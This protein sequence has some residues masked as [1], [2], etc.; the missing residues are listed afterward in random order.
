MFFLR[1]YTRRIILPTSPNT[2]N[3]K[4]V[5]YQWS[6]DLIIDDNYTML[7]PHEWKLISAEKKIRFVT[8]LSNAFSKSNNKDWGNYF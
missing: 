3:C 2:A 4:L 7:R 5:Y 1:Y 6:M 8:Y